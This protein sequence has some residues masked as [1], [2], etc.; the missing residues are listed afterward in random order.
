ML[1]I[2]IYLSLGIVLALSGNH[3]QLSGLLKG[4]LK[5][6]KVNEIYDISEE[7]LKDKAGHFVNFLGSSGKNTPIEKWQSRMEIG[8]YLLKYNEFPS[9][10]V[11]H[12]EKEDD[13]N[14][15]S[16]KVLER[17]RLSK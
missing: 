1:T 7:L 13:K 17:I 2:Y 8:K 9:Q 14:R 5:Q 10:I 11:D 15:D 3:S 6:I 4:E 12:I 16:N